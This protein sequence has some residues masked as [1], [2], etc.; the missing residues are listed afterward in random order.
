MVYICFLSGLIPFGCN[1]GIP[2]SGGSVTSMGTGGIR[3]EHPVKSWVDFR[4]QNVVI[5]RYDYSCG[6]A[7]LATIMQYYFEDSVTEEEI[8]ARIIGPMTDDDLLDREKNG[9]SLLDLK[10][11]AEQMGYQAAAVRLNYGNIRLLKGPVLIHLVREDYKHFAVLK[12]SNGDRIYLADP[13]RGNI[14][15]SVDRFSEEWSGI[16]LVLGREGFGVPR[17]YPMALTDRELELNEIQ[18]ARRSLYAR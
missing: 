1:P 10:K 5:Q 2:F 9:L 17:T 3:T 6:A 11:C 15:M 7:A 4:D 12:G 14:R 16:A 18:P 8:L 13:S